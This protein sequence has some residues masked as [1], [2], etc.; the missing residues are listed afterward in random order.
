MPKLEATA[1]LEADLAPAEP[2]GQPQPQTQPPKAA[3]ATSII[4]DGEPI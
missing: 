2:D 3:S 4:M 1:K